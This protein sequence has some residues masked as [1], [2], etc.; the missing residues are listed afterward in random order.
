MFGDN[1][2]VT[3]TRAIFRLVLELIVKSIS[4]LRSVLYGDTIAM[5][6]SD[7]PQESPKSIK[8]SR[9]STKSSDVGPSNTAPESDSETSKRK[10]ASTEV[11]EVR[12][13]EKKKKER[14]EPVQDSGEEQSTPS[15]PEDDEAKKARKE[16]RRKERALE[17]VAT[18]KDKIEEQNAVRT[19]E[20][21]LIPKKV[22][23]SKKASTDLENGVDVAVEKGEKKRKRKKDRADGD[24][25]AHDH[26]PQPKKKK[27]KNDTGLPD[28]TEDAALSDQA[29]KGAVPVFFVPSSSS[30]PSIFNSA[31]AYAHDQFN[32]PGSWKFNKAR[33]NWLIRNLWSGEAVSINSVLR[34]YSA[35]CTF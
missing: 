35:D 17:A 34:G 13:K 31:L 6:V 14:L 24:E 1:S 25:E 11:K 12:K 5:S 9:K 21:T 18:P 32:D 10:E 26:A 27:R 8:R 23:K 28:P 30:L 20:V 15:R 29:R 22:K 2:P 33:Q 19:A 4:T 3:G 7:A 16:K